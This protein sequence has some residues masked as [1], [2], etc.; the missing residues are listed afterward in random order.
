MAE[1]NKAV[2]DAIVQ[3]ISELMKS[4]KT[5]AQALAIARTESA[6]PQNPVRI[7]HIAVN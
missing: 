2:K 6:K 5:R 1:K 3:K 7:V 4:G